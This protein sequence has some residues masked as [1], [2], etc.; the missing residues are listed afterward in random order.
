MVSEVTKTQIVTKRVAKIPGTD[1]I[2]SAFSTAIVPTDIQ[3]IK[4]NELQQANGIPTYDI[5]VLHRFV[6]TQGTT[7]DLFY[8]IKTFEVIDDTANVSVF[9]FDTNDPGVIVYGMDIR[10]VDSTN[11]RSIYTVFILH[12][13]YTPA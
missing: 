5:S 10:K 6:G 4:L 12:G 8:T 13:V 7:I 1:I 9:D 11:G 3:S 2:N